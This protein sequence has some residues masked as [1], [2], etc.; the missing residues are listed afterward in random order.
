MSNIS[1]VEFEERRQELYWAIRSRILTDQEMLEVRACGIALL[2]P[3][4]NNGTLMWTLE[5]KE[6]DK[7]LEFNQLLFHQ[8]QLRIL[9]GIRLYDDTKG[10]KSDV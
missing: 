4:F 10:E 6:H 5:Y 8:A 2:M 7:S 3:H 9:A 1:F